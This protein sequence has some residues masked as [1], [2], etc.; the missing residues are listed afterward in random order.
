M[1]NIKGGTMLGSIY[2]GGR[3]A[4]V[5]IGF[6]PPTDAHYGQFTNDTD[7]KT[8]GHITVNISGGTIGNDLENQFFAVEVETYGKNAQEIESLRKEGLQTFKNNNKIPNTDFELYDSVLVEGSTTKYK[9]LYR[10]VH[11]KGG[12]VFGGSMGRLTLLDNSFNPL[13][14]QLGQAKSTTVN[15]TGGTI[16]SNV[17][18][19]GEIGTVRDNTYVTIGGIRDAN[20]DVTASGSPTIYRDVY[21]G[22]YGSSINS[23]D[24]KTIVT[25][26]NGNVT[27]EYGYSPLQWTGIVG[28]GTELNIYGGWIKK[29]VYGGGE[30][31]S[32]GIIN[33]VLDE[34]E[35]ATEAD[36]PAGKVIFRKNPTTNYYTVYA[37]IVKHADETNSFALSW[38]YKFEYVEVPNGPSYLGTTKVN[39]KGGRIGITGKDFMGPFAANGVT[40]ISPIDG[41]TLT[42]TEKKAARMDN[43]DVFGGGKGL[44]GDRYEMAFLANV[45]S[46]EV[47]IEYPNNGADA[48]NYKDKAKDNEGN[49][50]DTY[51]N[52][53]ITGSVYAGAE[54]GHVM[55]NTQLTLKNGLVGH[56][57]YGGGKGKG[58][59]SQKILKIGSKPTSTNPLTYPA[60]AYTNVNIYSITAGKVYGN[61]K[62][63]M[64]GGIVV[65]NVYGGGNMGSVGK[66]N[67]AGGID[68]YSSTGYGE[69]LE[70]N[71]WDGESLN[72][73]AFLNSGKTEVTITGGSIG[74][75]KENDAEDSMKDGLPYGNVFGGCRGESAPNIRESPRYHYSPQFYSGYTNE[76]KVTIGT[77]S[78]TAGPTILG[79]VYGGGQDGHVR[80]D[81]SVTIYSGE[82]GI[83]Y[84]PNVLKDKNKQG[85][86]DLNNAVWLHRGNVYGAGSGIG[87]YQYDFNY[88]G[89]FDDDD[90][91]YNGKTIK[92]QDYST[93]A[94]SV[95]RFTNVEINGGTIHRNVYGG[96]SLSSVGAP[97]IPPTRSDNPYYKDDP[98]SDHG[99][100]KQSLNEVIING[101]TIGDVNSRTVGYG[102]NVYGASRGLTELDSQFATS[103]WTKVE[104]NSGYIYGNVFGGG[105]AGSVTMDTKVIIGDT[106]TTGSGAP[107]R[108][109]PAVQP[110]A[111]DV[112]P[113]A[114][115]P[116]INSTNTSTPANVSTEAPDARS[117]RVNRANQ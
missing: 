112:Q 105:E 31:A 13:W 22:G 75:Y 82:I 90:A 50:L 56:A 16:K 114:A 47:T 86:T 55:G 44:A 60:S 65:R 95:T 73:Q 24:S 26:T 39:I 107:R 59:Y 79:S 58:T 48:D 18:G 74:Y 11:T 96:G 87:K 45:G 25:S 80:R 37:N 1:T 28:I 14:A 97:K 100:G 36:V 49:S 53:C 21:G 76:T 84:G 99:P 23:E 101:G 72:S 2:G 103:V 19:G 6:N 94:G 17:Y 108:A 27:T 89:D 111:A 4:S 102:G 98:D 5:G 38:P 8:Y 10:T 115:A 46:T 29:S 35:Y 64:S 30:M 41:H 69:A 67:Y 68:D 91:T 104:A 57:I 43:G 34:T 70:G 54:N 9:Y 62:V 113:N 117:I 93:S 78:G 83:A 15:I 51:A 88:D 40:A 71:L 52:D 66:G 92:E 85:I 110:N 116:A 32:V 33:Y 12:N 63:D 3:L 77:E 106:P 61:T 42:D 109:A 7:D 20:G 81:A